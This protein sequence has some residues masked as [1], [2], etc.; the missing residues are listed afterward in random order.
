ME[1][2]TATEHSKS[3]LEHASF[4]FEATER[5]K[6]LLERAS[7]PRSKSLFE[8]ASSCIRRHFRACCF[9]FE[10]T[11]FGSCL[12]F[13]PNPFRNR[14]ASN[15]ALLRAVLCASS[16]TVRC[17]MRISKISIY[18]LFV[19]IHLFTHLLYA[20]LCKPTHKTPPSLL[21]LQHLSDL[22]I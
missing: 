12:F 7:R 20:Q 17:H 21:I 5:L 19:Y 3:V 10:S 14:S 22:G 6:P 16:G 11:Y 13:L 15:C 9:S 8:H 2:L 4:S 18:I 1:R